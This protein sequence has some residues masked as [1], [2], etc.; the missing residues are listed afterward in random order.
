MSRKASR[1]SADLE[2]AARANAAPGHFL[3]RDMSFSTLALLECRCGAQGRSIEVPGYVQCAGRVIWQPLRAQG[4]LHRPAGKS[5][6]GHSSRGTDRCAERVRRTVDGTMQIEL[7]CK[8]GRN[9]RKIGE[10]AA[11]CELNVFRV[12]GALRVESQYGATQ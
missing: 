2:F 6:A 10:D 1:A 9:L 8:C 4:D 5:A 11:E 3:E 7:A 12:G